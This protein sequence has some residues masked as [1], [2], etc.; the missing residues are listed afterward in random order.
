MEGDEE[1]EWTYTGGRGNSVTD[2]VLRNEETRIKVER[3]EVEGR[4]DSDHHPVTMKMK[5]GG[6]KERRKGVK[7]KKGKK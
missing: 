5:S 7:V 4:V 1:E 6:R 2:Y 3:L